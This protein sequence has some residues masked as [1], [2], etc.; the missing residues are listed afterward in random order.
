MGPGDED[1]VF[2]A[3]QRMRNNT[4]L[5]FGLGDGTTTNFTLSKRYEPTNGPVHD[6]LIYG[7]DE[8][9]LTIEVNAVPLGSGDFTIQSD[10]SIELSVA[11]GNGITVFWGGKFYI[12]VAFESED[13]IQQIDNVGISG[14]TITSAPSIPLEEI[15]DPF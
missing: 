3:T 2:A 15:R 11:P 12:V 7:I 10:A 8:N 13:F 5:G 4:T 9:S 1:V 14:R 6:R